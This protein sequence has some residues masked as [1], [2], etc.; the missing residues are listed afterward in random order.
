Q[1]FREYFEHLKRDGIIAVTRWEFQKPREALRVVS[2]AIEA[3]HQLGVT[4]VSRHFIVISEGDLD[5]DGIPVAVLAKKSPFE[6][7]EEMAVKEHL[8]N[9]DELRL[10][11]SPWLAGSNAFSRLIESNDPEL[12]TR[13]YDYNVTAVTDNAPFFFF[14]LKPSRLFHLNST[15]SAMDWKVNLGVAVLLMLL[16]ISIVAVLAFLV[17]P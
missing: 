15:S 14:T 6:P 16:L 17:L 4:D 9:Y 13:T 12:F 8:R 2:V 1:A 11:Y 7:E 5:E 10:L 3:L